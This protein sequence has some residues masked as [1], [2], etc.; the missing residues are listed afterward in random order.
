MDSDYIL[1]EESI[2]RLIGWGCE[3]RVTMGCGGLSTGNIEVSFPET[4]ESVVQAGWN[5][6][7]KGRIQLKV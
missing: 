7:G 2:D 3:R 1:L 6:V 4:E 5:E